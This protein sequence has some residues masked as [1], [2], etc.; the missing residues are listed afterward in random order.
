MDLHPLIAKHR[1]RWHSKTVLRLVY[2]AYYQRMVAACVPGRTLEIGGGSGHSREFMA[3]VLSTDILPAPWLD[4]VCDA[5][6]LPFRDGSFSNIVM[7]DVLHHLEQPVDFV[8]EASRV[9]QPG[10]RVV[11]LDP[12]ITPVSWF[13]YRF[14]HQEAVEMRADP[15][16]KPTVAAGHATRRRDPFD[17]NQ[18]IPTLLFDRHRS[19][20]EA[21]FPALRIVSLQRFSFFAYPLSGGFKAWAL[22]PAAAVRTLIALEDAL[23]PLLGPVMAF[24][25]M[26][27]LERH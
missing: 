4:A 21:A 19:R 12:A 13:F 16:S 5:Q 18:A 7:L 2:G 20:F 17:S 1:D 23:E 8:A 9:L 15:L 6:A 22:I 14:L 24:R 3:D 11:M 26:A 10:G 25:L 27:V